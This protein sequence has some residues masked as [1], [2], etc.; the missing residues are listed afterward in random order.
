MTLWSF[1]LF[2]LFDVGRETLAASTQAEFVSTKCEPRSSLSLTLGPLCH[3]VGAPWSH[4]WFLS[5]SAFQRENWLDSGKTNL[6]TAAILCGLCSPFD[7]WVRPGLGPVS[8]WSE[9]SIM[10]SLVDRTSQTMQ[11]LEQN[12]Y[13]EPEHMASNSASYHLQAVWRWVM[14]SPHWASPSW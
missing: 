13:L 10:C 14:C 2:N 11:T 12:T 4:V 1:C 7:D 9:R 3:P 8:L 6:A 5:S